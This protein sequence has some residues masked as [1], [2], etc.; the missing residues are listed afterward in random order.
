MALA[1]SFF[2]LAASTW[3]QSPVS[4]EIVWSSVAYV[5]HGE[6]EPLV[7]VGRPA[8]TPLGAQQ[9]LSQGAHFRTRYLRGT[10]VDSRSGDH[11]IANLDPD[12]LDNSEITILSTDDAY[13]AS[14]A[15]AF[16][17]GVYPPATGTMAGNSGGAAASRLAN[18]TIVDFPLG[19]YQYP[20]I[21]TL[22]MSG[23]DSVWLQGHRDCPSKSHSELEI[24]KSEEIKKLRVDSQPLF[25]KFG[26]SLLGPSGFFYDGSVKGYDYFDN[27]FDVFD[28]IRY[29]YT[30]DNATHAL[31]SQD[32]V[33][34][35]AKYTARQQQEMHGN[36]SVSGRESGDQIRAIAGKTLAARI[37]S[38]IRASSYDPASLNSNLQRSKLTLIF[39]SHEPLISFFALSGLIN[40]NSRQAFEALPSPGAT[41]V[42]E[43]FTASNSQP[44]DGQ[45]P[46][47]AKEL[48]VRFL[49]RSSTQ[50]SETFAAYP[51][52]G[53][54]NA[55]WQMRY[56][57]FVQAMEK[58]NIPTWQQWCALCGNGATFCPGNNAVGSG[59]AK[60][61]PAGGAIG[62]LSQAGAG[63]I[64]AVVTLAVISGL[65]ALAAMFGD[66]RL[67][68]RNQTTGNSIEDVA[69]AGGFKGV[70]KKAKDRDVQVTQ[71]G[72]RHERSGSWELRSAGSQ[73]HV[74]SRHDNGS[75]KFGIVGPSLP[76]QDEDRQLPTRREREVSPFDDDSGS[77]FGAS[78][79]EPRSAI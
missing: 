40:G 31:V 15:T 69:A 41:I 72:I 32:D 34:S 51:L 2:A 68:R 47:E 8:L 27:A 22:S 54:S 57:D 4:R 52:F 38:Q 55:D 62:T 60:D 74:Q 61:F 48:F 77:I 35:L 23:S 76:R 16:M 10:A 65:A 67:S 56:T 63:A 3:A 25:D 30:H 46:P 71:G 50:D 29:N 70:E 49:H 39:G 45:R 53:R 7:A 5:Y 64:G 78:P 33:N 12:A 79:V 18:N 24:A 75:S 11:D 14:S 36:L 37:L 17:Q 21:Q 13:V 20:K 9:M 44:G 6:R 59:Q 26:Q 43:T 19:G 42:F 73:G 1:L 66:V 28:F 58:I